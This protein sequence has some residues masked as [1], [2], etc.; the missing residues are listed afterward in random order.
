MPTWVASKR[1][2]RIANYL[3]RNSHDGGL[4]NLH[5]YVPQWLC[6]H[7]SGM[8]LIAGGEAAP[9]YTCLHCDE[10]CQP[11]NGYEN[12]WQ[13]K[14]IRTTEIDYMA[15]LFVLYIN[16]SPQHIMETLLRIATQ[17]IPG[18]VHTTLTNSLEHISHSR[19][20]CAASVERV[21][22][23]NAVSRRHTLFAWCD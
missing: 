12:S 21:S 9:K 7:T 4:I 20:L 10:Q 3:H 19:L 2:C 8:T 23:R 11:V 17:K 1:D 22:N 16:T 13:C 14:F 18:R 15:Q 5:R 6:L